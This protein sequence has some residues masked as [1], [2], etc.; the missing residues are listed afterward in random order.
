[1]K[2]SLSLLT[3]Q[4]SR[5]FSSDVV[6]VR[7]MK[8][9]AKHLR[10]C[11]TEFE[12]DHYFIDTAVSEAERLVEH[13]GLNP[14]SRILDVG[15][16]PGRLAIGIL[17]QV[18]QVQH[19]QGVDIVR[20]RIK[21]CQRHI[22]RQHPNFHF[23]HIDIHNPRYNPSGKPLDAGFQFPFSDRQFDIIYLFSVFSH[24]TSDEVHL[25][26]GEFQRLLAPSGKMFLTAFVEEAVPDMTINPK[27]YR[28]T[29]KGPLH[30]VRYG[31]GFFEALLSE[32]RFRIDCM[33]RDW[34]AD[35][36]NCLHVS[37]SDEIDPD[38]NM[39]RL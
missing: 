14:R 12:D 33:Q 18:G 37:R 32:H 35:G 7:N 1:M 26:M 36:Q 17:N 31:R 19:Y 9:P 39:D 28:R 2:I 23:T 13:F 15:C 8:L 30:C 34:S 11:G 16:G 38:Q 10:L 4:L 3:N 25:Y 24:M 20:K 22:A 21:W 5:L 6:H 29:W 27:D